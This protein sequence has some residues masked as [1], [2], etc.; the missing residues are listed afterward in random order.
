MPWDLRLPQKSK[1]QVVT[2]P[3][4]REMTSWVCVRRAVVND[5]NSGAKSLKGGT[6]SDSVNHKTFAQRPRAGV[7]E[8]ILS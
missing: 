7:Q 1:G 3:L 6:L 5:A 4:G 8:A 2:S